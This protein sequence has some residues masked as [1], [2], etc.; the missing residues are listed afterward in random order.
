MYALLQYI[1]AFFDAYI[2]MLMAEAASALPSFG[3]D[4]PLQTE[5]RIP[6]AGL[7]NDSRL[8]SDRD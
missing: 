5:P 3:A 2:H 4:G 8:I 1:N 7:R 6:G